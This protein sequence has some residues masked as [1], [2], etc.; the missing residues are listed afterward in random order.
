M[1]KSGL[2]HFLLKKY[3]KDDI[4]SLAAQM[5]YYLLLSFF[6][7]LIF[8]LNL[9]GNMNIPVDY[10]YSSL[11]EFL[12]AESYQ[13]VNSIIT[14]VFTSRPLNIFFIF[15][16]LSFSS[17]GIQ[18]VIKGLD[19]AYNFREDRGFVYLF[20]ISLFLTVAFAVVIAVVMTALVFGESIGHQLFNRL[21]ILQQF[22][23]FW[24]LFRYFISILFMVA[25]FTFVYS[26]GS[27]K[28]IGFY[29]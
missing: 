9:L 17:Q 12:P 4:S 1:H 21:H 28:N 8:L 27:D 7:F 16:T 22:Q 11:K 3:V 14:E 29:N 2:I 20:F 26:R 5:S 19:R 24:K 15:L 6:P 23:P 13:I 25:L 10:L 18:A